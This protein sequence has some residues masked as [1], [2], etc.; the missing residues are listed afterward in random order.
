[1]NTFLLVNIRAKQSRRNRPDTVDQLEWST[2][3]NTGG[4]QGQIG[5]NP[6]M[7]F[8][9]IVQRILGGVNTKLK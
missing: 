9:G 8:K 4:I 5:C 7:L 2:M 3:K 6:T 1:M